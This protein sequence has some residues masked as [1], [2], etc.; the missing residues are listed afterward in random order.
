MKGGRE[1]EKRREHPIQYSAGLHNNE[2]LKEER[3]VRNV[4]WIV[5]IN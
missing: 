2:N 5:E 4:K 3:T 1:T